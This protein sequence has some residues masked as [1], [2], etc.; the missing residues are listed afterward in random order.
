MSMHS[1]L[2]AEQREVLNLFLNIGSRLNSHFA[3]VGVKV[4][5]PHE[6]AKAAKGQLGVRLARQMFEQYIEPDDQIKMVS[7]ETE[8]EGGTFV[9]QLAQRLAPFRTDEGLF[10]EDEE[11]RGD[12]INRKLLKKVDRT[13]QGS[14]GLWANNLTGSANSNAVLDE[15]AGLIN[16]FV[17]L[18]AYGAAL[19]EAFDTALKTTSVEFSYIQD[20]LPIGVLV[21]GEALILENL[22]LQPEFESFFSNRLQAMEKDYYEELIKVVL[23]ESDMEMDVS[24]PSFESILE[25]V[26]SKRVALDNPRPEIIKLFSDANEG[27]QA[28]NQP[29]ND[30]LQKI[31]APA[32]K[33]EELRKHMITFLSELNLPLGADFSNVK[34]F[35]SHAYLYAARQVYKEDT[36]T[37]NGSNV[38]GEMNRNLSAIPLT[39]LSTAGVVP[40][41]ILSAGA[42][43]YIYELG[44]RLGMFRMTDMLVLMWAQGRLDLEGGSEAGALLYEYYKQR[45][46]RLSYEE[47][48]MVYRQALNLGNAD[49][50]NHMVPNEAFTVL[51]QQLLAEGMDYIKETEREEALNSLV[52]PAGIFQV[53]QDLQRNLSDH[54]GGKLRE[55]TLELYAQLQ[56]CV[57]I[58]SHREIVQRLAGAS[59]N[60]MWGV[61][62]NLS[63]Q[64]FGITP[65][66]SASR[67]VAV[68]GHKIFQWIAD[69]RGNSNQGQIDTE[70]LELGRLLS[71]IEAYVVAEAQL[72]EES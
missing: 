51:W 42:L 32:D 4:N 67:T 46:S 17:S 45:D 29:I 47:R 52:S 57:R 11:V 25:E 55:D 20:G 14:G 54:M 35:F 2:N 43:Y 36:S 12:M 33:R 7:N 71:A 44:S 5:H 62:D 64:E 3:T 16:H 65:N 27:T 28:A 56:E 18:S 72:D 21:A 19:K 69:Y 1:R 9:V 23:E 48:R 70:N 60:N 38:V 39:G 31:N 49:L 30:Y 13:L 58:L 37:G 61:I 34:D 15:I 53:T 10:T 26:S 41:N 66:I 63:R 6:L 24:S 68:E 40:Q 50:L 8:I 22:Q 59:H